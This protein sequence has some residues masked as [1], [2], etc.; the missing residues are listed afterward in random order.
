MKPRGFK[1]GLVFLTLLLSVCS[2]GRFEGA[3]ADYEAAAAYQ[4]TAHSAGGALP[5]QTQKLVLEGELQ[6]QVADPEASEQTLISILKRYDAYTAATRRYEHRREYTIRVPAGSYEPLVAEVRRTGKVL[7]SFERTEDVSLTYYDLEGRLAAKQELLK[8][9][10]SYLGK[11]KTM[12]EILA[13]EQRIAEVQYEI[14]RTG[15]E[16]RVLSNQIQYARIELMFLGPALPFGS[17]LGER[18]GAVW[19]SFGDCLSIAA[20]VLLGI[21]LYGIPGILTLLVFYW[22]LF[23]KIGLVRKLWRIVSEK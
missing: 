12:E 3:A 13:V 18:I 23:G 19:G 11:A 14:D 20:A 22:V 8:T 9:F 7:K 17:D 15:T 6:V 16:F 2:R 10:Q 21:L 5:G 1:Q 4:S